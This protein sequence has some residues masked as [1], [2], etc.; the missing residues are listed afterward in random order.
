MLLSHQ[1]G[2]K[3]SDNDDFMCSGKSGNK[4][5]FDEKAIVIVG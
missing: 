2:G 3:N 5:L 4:L 1:Q